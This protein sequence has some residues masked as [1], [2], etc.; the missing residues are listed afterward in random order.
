MRSAM[1]ALLTVALSSSAAAQT[2]ADTS[3]DI[4]IL[5]MLP[6]D[7]SINGPSVDIVSLLPLEFSLSEPPIAVSPFTSLVEFALPAAAESSDL[8]SAD[9][10]FVNRVEVL[11]ARGLNR[12]HDILASAGGHIASFAAAAK[13][14]PRLAMHATHGAL[15]VLDLIS[16]ARALGQGHR[17]AN[18]LFESGN[19]TAMAIAKSAAVG[20]QIFAVEQLAKR[21]RK[22]ALWVSVA[23][24]VFMSMV[25]ANNLAIGSH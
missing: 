17:E 7:F 21:N 25:V 19:I 20:A 9:A 6:L 5:S 1:L 4:D 10:T 18:P 12:T 16:T 13:Q 22:A 14:E 23:T 15:Q 8:L 2:A 3:A 11:W 24:N